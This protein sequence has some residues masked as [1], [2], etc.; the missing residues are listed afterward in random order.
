MTASERNAS[1]RELRPTP[2]RL[3]NSRSEGNRSPGFNTSREMRSTTCSTIP[4]LTEVRVLGFISFIAN[5]S[6]SCIFITYDNK[7]FALQF[8]SFELNLFRKGQTINYY[9]NKI[10]RC[11]AKLP[12]RINN[13]NATANRLDLYSTRRQ[14]WV[15][16]SILGNA[17]NW[18]QWT[19]HFH[20]ITIALYQQGE[21]DRPLFLVHTYSQMEGS[22]ER[23][24]FAVEAMT[25]MGNL[26][27]HENELLQFPC[28]AGHQLACR[29][30]FLESCKL[31]P[32]ASAGTASLADSG[33][34]IGTDHRGRQSWRR[35]LS[36]ESRWRGQTRRQAHLRNCW[37]V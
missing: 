15:R 1:L 37:A 16:Q 4:S 23:I 8:L 22:Q 6:C 24:Q 11:Q 2:N 32:D 21:D 28:G 10:L 33:Q 3:H 35:D 14:P 12:V 34:K 18:S 25:H 20:D 29:R 7:N 31:S 13:Y 30:T 9:A 26:V 19:P 5:F 27:V 17:L 36:S